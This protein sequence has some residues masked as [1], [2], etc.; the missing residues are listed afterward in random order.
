MLLQLGSIFQSVGKSLLDFGLGALQSFTSKEINRSQVRRE[1]DLLRLRSQFGGGAP[2]LPVAGIPMRGMGGFQGGGFGT[3]FVPGVGPT[4]RVSGVPTG[5]SAEGVLTRSR[6][7]R[8]LDG[9]NVQHFRFDGTDFVTIES[10]PQLTGRKWR[11]D[12]VAKNAVGGRGKFV[13]VP[14]RRMNPINPR[15]MRRSV[16]RIKRGQVV[17]RDILKILGHNTTG[18]SSH[19]STPSTRRRG[20]K[21]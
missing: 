18:R 5:V 2:V 19:R 9:C 7:T 10:A 14:G 4:T 12:E 1:E 21:K 16:V 3:M 17:C 15:A 13:P 6:F 8:T 20:A 11:F